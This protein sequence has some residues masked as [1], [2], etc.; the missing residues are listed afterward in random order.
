M[1]PYKYLVDADEREE[2]KLDLHG[3]II[4]VEEA[5]NLPKVTEDAESFEI[6]SSQ[7]N[8]CIK[9]LA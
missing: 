8:D 3:S 5:H 4:I 7:L 1:M 2:L 9:A 6:S